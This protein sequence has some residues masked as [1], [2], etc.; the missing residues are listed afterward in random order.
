MT[1]GG[2]R[3]ATT[4]EALEGAVAGDLE[5]ALA[6]EER[7]VWVL[8]P[9]NL[10][11][12]HLRRAVAERLGGVAGVEFIT[13]KDA[14]RRM[15][16][17]ALTGAG[18]RPMPPGA[19]ELVLRRLLDRVPDGSYF[20]GLRRFANAA[21]AVLQALRTLAACRWTPDALAEAA[22]AAGRRDPEAPPR[23]RELADL[24]AR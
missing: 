19:E 11:A 8:V 18:A 9:N 22:S 4:F 17:L 5:G 16:L 2:I 10:V 7:P 14:A 20:A 15:A 24:W 1:D 6:R 3:A 12:L 23:L 21:P 13:L